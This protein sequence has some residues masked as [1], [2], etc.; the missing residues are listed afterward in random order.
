[1]CIR[2]TKQPD[3]DLGKAV[4]PGWRN[5]TTTNRTFGCPTIRSDIKAPKRRSVGDNNN[6]GDDTNAYA[7]L[8]PAQY[9]GMGV[10]DKDFLDSR[11]RADLQTLFANAGMKLNDGDFDQV[12]RRAAMLSMEIQGGSRGIGIEVFRRAYNEYGDARYVGKLPSWWVST[13]K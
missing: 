2:H 12:Y 10:E 11:E 6:Y 5:D 3:I 9:A 4:A 7:L 1:M 13:R 8:H